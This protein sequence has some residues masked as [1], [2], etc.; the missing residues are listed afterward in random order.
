MSAPIFEKAVELGRLVGQSEE[1]QA[2]KRAHET[3]GEHDDLRERM[4]QLTQLAQQIEQSVAQDQEPPAETVDAYNGLLGLIQA[5]SAY[6]RVVAT[7]TAF[8]KLMLKVDEQIHEGIKA[9]AASRIITL[10]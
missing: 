8:D 5:E 1:Y 2:L 10:G 4:G 7:Q 3:V 9:G 6:Q